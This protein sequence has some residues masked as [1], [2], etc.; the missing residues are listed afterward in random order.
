MILGR[1]YCG[2]C[3]LGICLFYSYFVKNCFFLVKV[4]GFDGW[5]G[6]LRFFWWGGVFVFL[7]VFREFFIVCVL[8]EGGVYF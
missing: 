1:R 8:V 4:V 3:F 6:I 7:F 5:G 2:G